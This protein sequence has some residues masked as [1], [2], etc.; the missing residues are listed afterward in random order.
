MADDKGTPTTDTEPE[1]TGDRDSRFSRRSYL[2]LG[3]TAAAL[4]TF[5]AATSTT[6]SAA[7]T[8][9]I[10]EAGAD[11][12]GNERIDSVLERVA[13]SGVTVTFPPGTYL[14]NDFNLPNGVTLK[15][16]DAT[17]VPTPRSSKTIWLIKASNV[18]MDGFEFDYRNVDEPPMFK[19]RANNFVFRNIIFRGMQQTSAR[20]SAC[21]RAEVPNSSSQGLIQNVYMHEGSAPAGGQDNRKGIFLEHP[22]EGHLIID[23]V[24]MR[25]WGENT[26]YCRSS[27][28]KVTIKNSYFHNTNAGI[29]VGGVT[30]VKNCTFVSDG[31]VPSQEW[32]GGAFQPGV[33]I[34]GG[35][36]NADGTAGDVL[37]EDCDFVMTGPD[38]GP[39]LFGVH[40]NSGYAIMRNCRARM[41]SDSA[42]RD[43]ANTGALD[44]ILDGLHVTGST[45]DVAIDT[46]GPTSVTKATD[47]HVDTDGSISGSS[48]VRN[49]TSTSDVQPA[50]PTPPM[51]SPPPLGTTPKMDG[52]GSVEDWTY[53]RF[54]GDDDGTTKASYE[55]SVSGDLQYSTIGGATAQDA[56]VIDGS[57]A[58]GT[59]WSGSDA[60]AFT[61]DITAFDVEGPA[62]VYIDGSQ[63]DV[64]EIVQTPTPT[65]TPEPTAT[66]TPEPTA[67]PTPTPTPTPEPTATP[68]P[69]PTP[70][71]EPTWNYI[72][73]EGN[74]DSTSEGTY[75]FSVSGDLEHSTRNGATVQD[76][77][78][79]DGSTATGSV[80]SGADAYKF[81]GDVK[82][83]RL[84]G[85]ATV[86]FTSE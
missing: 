23:R 57:T 67:T 83:L 13:G 42:I 12:T 27:P 21:L 19:F 53:L 85:T 32:S 66:A 3:A 45:G 24:W 16:T 18:T 40:A 22:N 82:S 39:A 51:P 37:V 30:D 65:P 62:T 43:N 17:I 31:D 72:R 73:F 46:S 5:G 29:R 34:D 33:R 9:D 50:D 6:T 1:N 63:V 48:K 58:T 55:F 36:V 47:I 56:D 61:G 81:T 2:K 69:T 84:N 79:I 41:A 86:E 64:S 15:G 76:A 14:L 8:V 26:I 74:N 80:W 77:D 38:H 44:L 52:D 25:H 54:E 59:V 11:P 75:E 28:G 4:G 60:Y 10:V 78:V 70:T 71:P 20:S 7:S 49:A 68:T 35:L